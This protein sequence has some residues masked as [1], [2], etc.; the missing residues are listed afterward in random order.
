MMC[1]VCKYDLCSEVNFSFEDYGLE[2]EGIIFNCICLNK[3]CDVS[4]IEIYTK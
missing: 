1:P 3:D 2:G 4:N